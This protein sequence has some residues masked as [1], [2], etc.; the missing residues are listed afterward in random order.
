[1]PAI[2]P[3]DFPSEVFPFQKNVCLP[4]VATLRLTSVPI[5]LPFS[6]NN[7]TVILPGSSIEQIIGFPAE[8]DEETILRADFVVRLRPVTVPTSSE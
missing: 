3:T 6:D 4:A 8:S 5:F 7:S 1:M 2:D